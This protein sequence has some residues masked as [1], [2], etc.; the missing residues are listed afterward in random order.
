LLVI[1]LAA[2]LASGAFI[3]THAH[4]NCIGHGCHTCIELSLCEMVLGGL[5]LAAL[6]AAAAASVRRAAPLGRGSDALC[7][8][9]VGRRRVAL[10]SD[11]VRLNF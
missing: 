6:F 7:V 10:F 5:G 9:A 8:A 4:H 2:V 3:V 1:L 11:S